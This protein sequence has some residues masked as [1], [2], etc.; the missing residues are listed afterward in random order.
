MDDEKGRVSYDLRG[1]LASIGAGAPYSLSARSRGV[2][3]RYTHLRQEVRGPEFVLEFL[4]LHI[5]QTENSL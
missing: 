3:A 1:I 2:R 4:Y 5:Y